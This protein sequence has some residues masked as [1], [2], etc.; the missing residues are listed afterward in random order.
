MAN[1]EIPKNSIVVAGY[2]VTGRIT[3]TENEPLANIF[4]VLY[5]PKLVSKNKKKLISNL[6]VFFLLETSGFRMFC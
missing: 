3:S 2:D 1:T 4:I 5:N 6:W